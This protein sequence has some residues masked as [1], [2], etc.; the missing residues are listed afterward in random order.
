MGE[1]HPDVSE[2]VPT[3]EV[4][5]R[6]TV[7]KR[8]GV[9]RGIHFIVDGRINM[10]AS[11]NAWS[12]FCSMVLPYGESGIEELEQE[13]DKRHSVAYDFVDGHFTGSELVGIARFVEEH[14]LR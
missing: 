11:G 8:A 1:V 6:L 14:K 13:P 9:G 12:A 4:S 5:D 3:K 2:H 7:A 10:E